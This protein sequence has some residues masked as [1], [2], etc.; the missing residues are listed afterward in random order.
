MYF[1]QRLISLKWNVLWMGINKIFILE[2]EMSLYIGTE[3]KEASNSL[4]K[5]STL[6]Q[7]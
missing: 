5:E 1:L 4:D 2:E 7:K 3:G 6:S